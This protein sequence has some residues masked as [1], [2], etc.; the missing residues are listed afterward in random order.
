MICS[1]CKYNMIVVE[2]HNI[3]LEGQRPLQYPPTY[4]GEDT[5]P[6]SHGWCIF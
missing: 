1:V 6:P 4:L 5:Y 2:Y 3:E